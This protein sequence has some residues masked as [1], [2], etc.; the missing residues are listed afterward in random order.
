MQEKELSA[1]G[2]WIKYKTFVSK[3]KSE[4]LKPLS[5]VQVAETDGVYLDEQQTLNLVRTISKF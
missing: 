1:L 3:S 2:P 5:N 4:Q